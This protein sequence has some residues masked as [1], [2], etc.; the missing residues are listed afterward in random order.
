MHALHAH[1]SPGHWHPDH[2]VRHALEAL[3]AGCLICAAAAVTV[4]GLGASVPS[5]IWAPSLSPHPRIGVVP[6]PPTVQVPAIRVA[7]RPGWH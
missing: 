6:A 4:V 5:A 3:L 2:Q 1:P 7:A